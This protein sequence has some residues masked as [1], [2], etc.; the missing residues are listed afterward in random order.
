M[1]I[2]SLNLKNKEIIELKTKLKYLKD[3][4]DNIN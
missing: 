1:M 3:R 4:V 2:E